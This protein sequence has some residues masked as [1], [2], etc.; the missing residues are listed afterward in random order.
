MK[1]KKLWLVKKKASETTDNTVLSG[2][3]WKLEQSDYEK[4]TCRHDPGKLERPEP[5]GESRQNETKIGN[6][7]SVLIKSGPYLR[8]NIFGAFSNCLY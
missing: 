1:A 6:E 2:H 7:D 3:H 8:Q 4:V 5:S